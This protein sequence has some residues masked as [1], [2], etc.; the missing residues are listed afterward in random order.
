MRNYYIIA[1]IVL[2]SLSSCFIECES[3]NEFKSYEEAIH[4]I[5]RASFDIKEDIDPPSDH[6]IN[7]IDYYS[8]DGKFGYLIIEFK[9]G[10]HPYTYKS[11]PIKHWKA[12]K[13]SENL[14]RYYNENI[15]SKFLLK[16][17]R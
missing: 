3:L 13:K 2:L 12:L 10:E 9:N 7:D 1:T 17:A 8:C 16:L 6:W 11:V 4:K 14:G 15:K 5:Q